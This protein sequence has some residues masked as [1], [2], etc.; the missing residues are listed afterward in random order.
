MTGEWLTSPASDESE[1]AEVWLSRARPP[2]RKQHLPIRALALRDHDRLERS[3][4]FLH[5]VFVSMLS[6]SGGDR[7]VRLALRARRQSR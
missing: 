6:T 4:G 7:V 5:R 2:N 1:G 3:K